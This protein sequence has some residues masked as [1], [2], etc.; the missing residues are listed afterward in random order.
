MTVRMG[1]VEVCSGMEGDIILLNG[2]GLRRVGERRVQWCLVFE[3]ERVW[4]SSNSAICLRSHQ[5]HVLKTASSV[6]VPPCLLHNPLRLCA[7]LHGSRGS[8]RRMAYCPNCQIMFD[9]PSAVIQHLNH[10][11]S[12]CARWFIPVH[13]PENLPPAPPAPAPVFKN[14]GGTSIKF[15]NAG[16]VFNHSDGFMGD[17]H[18]DK[19]SGERSQ[20]VFYPFS[21]KGEWQLAS[22]LSRTGLSMRFVDEFLSLD[23]V[24][25][26]FLGATR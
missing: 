5:V 17:F 24:S 15:P 10:P 26:P 13:T 12:S 6:K 16:H 19:F 14:S 23:M 8:T 22:F 1:S 20:N 7:I 2:E 21:S 4:T 25:L 11:Y 9:S 3:T 18:A